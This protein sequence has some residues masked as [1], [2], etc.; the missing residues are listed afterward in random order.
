M[1]VLL[2]FSYGHL[3]SID[4][5]EPFYKH[6][7]RKHYSDEA[8]ERGKSLFKSLGT[9][10][11]LTSITHRIGK[12]LSKEIAAKTGEEWTYRIGTKHSE[13]FVEDVVRECVVSGVQKLLTVP[14][15]PL[16]SLTGTIGYQRKVMD[17]LPEETTI[18]V[19]HVEPYHA[20]Q[21]FIQLLR[22]RLEQAFHWLP[23]HVKDKTEVVFTAHS[24]PGNERVH[25]EFIAQ[26]SELAAQLMKPLEGIPHHMSYRSAGALPQK[27][28]RPDV[29]DILIER[30]NKGTKAV[31][32]CELLS[33]IA[34][35]EVI[36]EVGRDAMQCAHDHGMAFVQTE[37]L[38]DA[39]DFMKVLSNLCIERLSADPE[40]LVEREQMANSG[41]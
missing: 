15:T 17:T 9:A 12:A 35:A 13:P 19:Y 7:L 34:N 24:L 21:S 33:I 30:A 32:V 26:Y 6:L 28:L 23:T 11:S 8:L 20:K 29:L 10:D 36:Q 4:D 14:L 27:W 2:L 1:N 25:E 37:Y 41:N 38:N 5:L 22:D 18:A 39:Y 16:A 3:Q 40:P 31:V